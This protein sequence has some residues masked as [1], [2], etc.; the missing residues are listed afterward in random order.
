MEQANIRFEVIVVPTEETFPAG[1]PASEAA[2]WVAKEKAL[3]C[4]R[5]IRTSPELSEHIGKPI[6][7]ADTMVVLGKEIIGKPTDRAHAIETL[8]RLS[9]KTHQV[10][11]GVCLLDHGEIHEFPQTTLVTFGKL[12]EAEAVFYVDNHRPFDKAGSYAIQEWIG[13]VAIEKI[14]GD[15]YN[16]MGLPISKVYH[17][18]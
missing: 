15:F 13:A 9:A 10:V 2:V 14:D 18:I 16:V 6:L 3:A 12:T 11:T 1:M 8:L 4:D 17:M 7:A 5:Y